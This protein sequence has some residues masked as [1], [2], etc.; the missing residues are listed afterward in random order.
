MARA[1]EAVGGFDEF[2]DPGASD[3]HR[4]LCLVRTGYSKLVSAVGT[5]DCFG[6][7]SLR[8]I[9][10]WLQQAF[11]DMLNAT[12]T[13]VLTGLANSQDFV[14]LVNAVLRRLRFDDAA[15]LNASAAALE[16]RAIIPVEPGATY[17]VADYL[18]RLDAV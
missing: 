14:A 1:A 16:R 5:R 7:P 17:P 11:R 6:L 8:R 4:H 3:F 13:Q 15:Q 12:W 18:Q 2:D 10:I 9:D